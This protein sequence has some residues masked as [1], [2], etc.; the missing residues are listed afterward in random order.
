MLFDLR[1]FFRLNFLP[2]T[3]H[4]LPP[5]TP[6]QMKSLMDVATYI[7]LPSEPLLRPWGNREQTDKIL[8]GSEVTLK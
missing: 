6:A 3:P 5:L 4:I 7:R 8:V 1:L 2:S